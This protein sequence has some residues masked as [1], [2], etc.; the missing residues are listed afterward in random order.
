MSMPTLPVL[1]LKLISVACDRPAPRLR[2]RPL[3]RVSR[4]C[5]HR[6]P[7]ARNRSVK[8]HLAFRRLT[9]TLLRSRGNLPIT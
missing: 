6:S 1:S 7:P 3:D 8:K 9:M 5:P 2:V 4:S